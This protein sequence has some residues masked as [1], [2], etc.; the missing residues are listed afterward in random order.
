MSRKPPIGLE[1]GWKDLK[2]SIDELIEMCETDFEG[3]MD[4]KKVM[5]NYSCAFACKIKYAR[6]SER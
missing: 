6:D 2:E 5:G 1:E 4:V 3:S